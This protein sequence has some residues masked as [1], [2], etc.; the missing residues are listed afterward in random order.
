MNQCI[1][2]MLLR[3]RKT[4]LLY[5]SF[6]FLL[7]LFLSH[8]SFG[9][10][11]SKKG[12]AGALE[13]LIPIDAR[14][15]AL[16]GSTIS[17]TKGVGALTWNPA[18][19][20]HRSND[21]EMLFSHHDYIADIGVNFAAMSANLG[22]YGSFA[23]SIKS[24]NLGEIEETTEDMPEGTGNYFSPSFFNLGATYAR[25][26]S[27]RLRAG[28][29]LKYVYEK[30][31]KT[32]AV[33]LAWDAG[34]QYIAGNTGL[35]FGI[36]LKNVGPSLRYEGPDLER[37]YELSTDYQ[38]FRKIQIKS[39]TFDLP[40]SLELGFAYEKSFLDVNIFTISG[41]FENNNYGND[42]YKTGIEYS[43]NDML[44]LRG[45][46]ILVTEE[47]EYIYHLSFGVGLHYIIGAIG[48]QID[49]AYRP[50]RIFKNNS[51][52]SIQLNL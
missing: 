13:L 3:F 17:I 52:I 6:L 30:I 8:H 7:T 15:F 39:A 16:G 2:I 29:T 4:S 35:H 21:F 26:I 31:Y 32:L 37:D 38:V 42:L 24:L 49:Y 51:I 11:G 44:F 12:T 10:K 36:V 41:S 9:G 46:Y 40:S 14:G 1:K 20:T 5:L 18:G 45:G 43:Y 50:V 34:V 33:G 48:L 47:K 28:I 19:I 27:D 25:N 22:E 23:F